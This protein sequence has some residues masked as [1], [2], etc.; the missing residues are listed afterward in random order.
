[1][2][3]LIYAKLTKPI[4]VRIVGWQEIKQKR[5]PFRTAARLSLF[6]IAA[7]HA[8][9]SRDSE[10]SAQMS[11]DR[12][13]ESD[14]SSEIVSEIKDTAAAI[15]GSVNARFTIT[16]QGFAEAISI[17]TMYAIA[18]AQTALKRSASAEIRAFSETILSETKATSAN[19]SNVVEESN[20]LLRMPTELDARHQGMLDNLIG[21]TEEN[22]DSRYIE[23]QVNA[24]RE[25][26]IHIESYA[27]DGRNPPIRQFAIDTLPE[28]RERIVKAE[29]LSNALSTVSEG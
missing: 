5:G 20:L 26:L 3:P 12:L 19:L 15:V 6:V 10:T 16:T 14:T 21:A 29:S 17:H 11:D 18:A 2:V 4:R 9:N 1:V 8:E 23:Q 13:V 24:A 27:Q 25:A 28:L 7:C 22:F